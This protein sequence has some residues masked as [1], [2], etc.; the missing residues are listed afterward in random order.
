VADLLGLDAA[1]ALL[2][3]ADTTITK[4]HYAML[5]LEVAVNAA[6][7]LSKSLSEVS[8]QNRQPS[9]RSREMPEK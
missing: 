4:R 8:G 6:E 3:H 5:D 1:R 2:G 9:V 7:T